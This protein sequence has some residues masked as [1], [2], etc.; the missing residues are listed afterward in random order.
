[1]SSAYFQAATSQPLVTSLTVSQLNGKAKQLLEQGLAQVWVEGEVSNFT[2]SAVGHWYF[3]LKDA[4]AQLSC[5][6]FAGR[7]QL[8]LHQPK[9]GDQLQLRGQVS[10]YEG[11]GQYQL[12]AQE[13]R[14]S[15][16]GDWLARLEMLKKKL[17]A[18]GLF[19]AERKRPLPAFVHRLGVITSLQG[20]ALRDILEV[21][22]RRW[23]LAEVLVYP[24]SVQGQEAPA[25]LRRALAQAQYH[26]QP[27]LLIL[28]RGGG[29]L[30][31]LQ[32]FNDETLARM[33][34][35]SSM[36]V[37]TGVGHETD[38][39]LVDFVSDFRAPT[40]SAAAE[41]VS[42]DAASL[43][44]QLASFYGRLSHAMGRLLQ[45]E[46]QHLDA[47][48]LRASAPDRLIKTHRDYL[49]RLNQRLV[50]QQPQRR[51]EQLRLQLDALQNRLQAASPQR[52]LARYQQS[53]E[54]LAERHQQAYQSSF[55]ADQDRLSHLASRLQAISPLQ[56]LAR[57]YAL[58][59]N[60]QGQLLRSVARVRPGQAIKLRLGDGQLDCRVESSQAK[61]STSTFTL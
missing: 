52:Q 42:P 58:A 48:A 29:S 19:A 4:R 16:E 37:V 39:T 23:P 51:L 45:R 61:A 1:M 10:L 34:A 53:L 5:V 20:A 6:M 11:R 17:Q 36:P 49:A 33:V 35:A 38:F 54:Q 32:A 14:L 15:G 26:G 31:D 25:A 27:Q 30:E 21:L 13:L 59:Q 47:M 18:E 50:A 44:D 7:N 8:T 28:A 46:A 56:T 43:K 9:N 12:L 22:R 41:A 40:P 2:A 24:A 60:E 57:G 55:K 3:T